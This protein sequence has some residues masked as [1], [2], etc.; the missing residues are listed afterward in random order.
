M[1]RRAGGLRSIVRLNRRST[2]GLQYVL[3]YVGHPVVVSSV[4]SPC[5]D[6]RVFLSM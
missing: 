1:G 3:D 2:L 5:W 4:S 6:G